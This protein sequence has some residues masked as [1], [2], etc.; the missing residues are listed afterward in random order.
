MG[1]GVRLRSWGRG[2]VDPGG[3]MRHRQQELV[4]M[5]E[6]GAFRVEA[7]S[8][9]LYR[10]NYL[11]GEAREAAL[12]ENWIPGRG[13]ETGSQALST[14][15]GTFRRDFYRGRGPGAAGT[16]G[17]PRDLDGARWSPTRV[18]APSLAAAVGCAGWT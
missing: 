9:Q 13:G 1:L 6:P 3:G 14:S 18:S 17:P 12:Y 4:S 15:S 2:Q 8:W 7:A 5:W 10:A 11:L 16:F